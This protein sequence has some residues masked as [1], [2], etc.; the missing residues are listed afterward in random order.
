MLR[1]VHLKGEDI[2]RV[3]KRLVHRVIKGHG[4]FIMASVG[5]YMWHHRFHWHITTGRFWAL[6]EMR[7][8][9]WCSK[10]EKGLL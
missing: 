1:A 10:K 2:K 7:V 5:G 8:P 9:D 3:M 4:F 6:D